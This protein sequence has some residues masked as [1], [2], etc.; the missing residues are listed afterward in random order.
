[1]GTNSSIANGGFTAAQSR[2]SKEDHLRMTLET[3]KGLNQA[4]RV[5]TLVEHGPGAMERLRSYG[6]DLVESGNGFWVDRPEGSSELP[7][8]L[9]MKALAGRLKKSGARLLPGLIV[10]DLVVEEGEARGAFGFSRDGR[11]FLIRSKAVILAAGGAG[12]IYRRNDN[13]R[14]ILGDGY[15]LAL[16]AGL[17]L[18]DLEFV[19][20]YPLVLA[21]PRLSMFMLYPPYPREVRLFN[22]KGENLLDRL[23]IYEDL[24]RAMMNQRDL[25]SLAL[26]E[27]SQKSDV[28]LDLRGV[29]EKTWEQYPLNFL[30]KSKFPFQERTFLIAPAVHFFMGGVGINDQGKTALPGLF[31]AGEVAWGVHGANRLGGNALTECAVFGTLAGRSAVEI[32]QNGREKTGRVPC[33]RLKGPLRNGRERPMSISEGGGGFLTVH[34]TFSGSSRT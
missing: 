17:K 4:S 20:F 29:P 14:S 16:R 6:I 15:A 12:G 33:L 9:L 11:P 34:G 32:C 30:K 19:Q 22:E 1:M 18:Y 31:A 3:G 28:Y 13:Q 10:F 2:F 25:F 21:E 26:Y 27:A 5:K 23:G 24:N 7:G 8:V